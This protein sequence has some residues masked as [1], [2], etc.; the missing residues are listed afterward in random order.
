M[1]HYL[2]FGGGVN[3]VALYLLMQDLGMEF[4]AVY[5]DHGADWP[6][7][8]EYVE[9]FRKKYPVTIITPE[10]KG[11][12]SI[13]EY[14]QKY[15]ETPSR[16]FRWCTGKFKVRP[17][18]KYFQSPCFVHL[19]V[20]AG[21]AHRARFASEGGRENRYLL[22]E[23]GINRDGCKDIIKKHGLSVPI[24]SGCFFCPFQRLS[25]FRA[26]RRKHP[27]LFCIAQNIEKKAVAR[28]ISEGRNPVYTKGDT[29]LAEIINDKQH[30][31]PG[32]E[33]LEYPPCQCGL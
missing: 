14:C 16:R 1:K 2:S 26:L 5:V 22:L 31:L 23:H 32:M 21:E 3:S 13:L 25:Q 10:Y 28:M 15:S 20:D 7:T 27:D 8:A 18:N 33:S 6:E 29:P 12:K 17:I 30:V 9:T 4:E 24:K 11:C 19:G